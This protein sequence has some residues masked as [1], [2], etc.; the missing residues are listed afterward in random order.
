MANNT[1]LGR[2]E[3]DFKEFQIDV[4][5][6]LSKIMEFITNVSRNSDSDSGA[7][8]VTGSG[9][10]TTGSGPST[11]VHHRASHHTLPQFN[12][13]ID[14]WN[15]RLEEY[16]DVAATPSDQKVKV[17]SLYMIGPAFSWYK[18]MV[19]NHYTN[20][21]LV[22]VDALHKR[23]GTDLYENPQEAL[24]ELRQEGSVADYQ[25]KFEALSNRV[26][27]LSEQW[28]VSFFITGLSDYLKCQ[29]RL[30]K[31]CSYPEAVSL[32]RLHEQNHVAL[33]NSFKTQPLT[34]STSFPRSRFTSSNF[35][36]STFTTRNTSSP[37]VSTTTPPKITNSTPNSSLST[38][39]P[40]VSKPPFKKFT[41]AELRE[42]RLQGLCYY[43]N[44][45]YN[46]TH[47]CKSQCLALLDKEDL[48][49]ILPTDLS[50]NLEVPSDYL[51]TEPEISY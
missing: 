1:R 43:C 2:L 35:T 48:D 34:S 30:A 51:P 20:E 36:P 39:V 50:T 47:K 19:R 38:S 3:I 27:G 18:W 31:P 8:Q 7:N 49:Q 16:F 15:F 5:D 29:L 25:T 44:E 17:A 14:D 32:A 42:R 23:F 37:L 45:K 10:E 41:T 4:R 6:Q 13:D 22:F 28:M 46:P 24:K 12:E 21:W 33:K 11:R 40:S 26:Q 9:S